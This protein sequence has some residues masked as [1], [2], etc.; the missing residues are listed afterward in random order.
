MEKITRT[1][2]NHEVKVYCES[3]DGDVHVDTVIV[4]FTTDKANKALDKKVKAMFGDT[5]LKHTYTGIVTKTLFGMDLEKFI[6]NAS[7]IN[8]D[9]VVFEQ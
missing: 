3:P 8:T 7:I 5:Y 9:A 4:T 6:E 2:Y 1:I